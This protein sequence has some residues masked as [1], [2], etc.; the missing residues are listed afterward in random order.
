MIRWPPRPI[1]D[2]AARSLP[3]SARQPLSTKGR[4]LPLC[5]FRLPFL[6]RPSV[7]PEQRIRGAPFLEVLFEY[8]ICLQ[9]AG[10]WYLSG[11]RRPNFRCTHPRFRRRLGAHCHPSH[12]P[13]SIQSTIYLADPLA[14]CRLNLGGNRILRPSLSIDR[15]VSVG[16]L[17]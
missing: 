14:S 2:R 7:C 11:V 9:S 5:P 16:F 4:Q 17:D 3:V 15:Y 8:Q 10:P 1:R 12:P 6:S 13:D